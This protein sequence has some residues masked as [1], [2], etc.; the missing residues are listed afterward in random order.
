MK[1]LALGLILWASWVGTL[2]AQVRVEITMEQEQFLPGEAIQIAVRITNRSGQT[3]HLGEE[4][5]WLTFTIETADGQV[6]SQTGPV[7]LLGGFDLE[8]SKVGI[9]RAN[10]EPHFSF[11][12]PDRYK[13]IA[14]LKIKAWDREVSSPPKFFTINEG[15]KL[16][17]QDF[18]VPS[19]TG[20]TNTRPEIRKY[21]LQ[22]ANYNRRSLRLY[23]RV[24]DAEAS[25]VFRVVPIGTLI[26]FSR[27]EP[28]IDQNSRL[29]LIY[30]NGPR[31]SSY[32][33]FDTDGEVLSRQTYDIT[34]TRPRLHPDADGN[35]GVLGG[36]RRV[37]STDIPPPKD[38]EP[39]SESG[40]TNLVVVPEPTPIQT[41]KE[42]KP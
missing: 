2:P 10:L 6:V 28:Q 13:I 3:L 7:P 26:S 8:S 42:Q 1:T 40:V 31:T 37:A 14:I 34:S 12:G 19:Q 27:P 18:G 35:I 33:I 16:W 38:I 17:Q 20:S 24:T 30:Q 5:D 25:R 41:N 22:Q 39:E 36:A 23:L 32:L 4:Q 9:K 29:H 11:L 21:I 15:A